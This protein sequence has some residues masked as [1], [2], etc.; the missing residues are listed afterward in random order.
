VADTSFLKNEVEE[1]VREQLEDEYKTKFTSKML[2]LVTDGM[3]EFDAVSQDGRIVAGIK[4]SSGLTSTGKN[5]SG[6]IYS[7]VAELYFLSLVNA[8][9]KLLVLTDPK[10][11]AILSRKMKDRLAP[12]LELK[13][14]ELSSEILDRVRDIR[15]RASEEVSGPQQTK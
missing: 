12:G 4:A 6:K 11:H 13:V 3:H 10:F 15:A 9:V 1:F 7:A 5:P 14:A 8:P 2:R